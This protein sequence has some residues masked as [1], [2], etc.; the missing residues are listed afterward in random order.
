MTDYDDFV[1]NVATM[2]DGEP[3]TVS[4]AQRATEATLQT[5]A[6]RL[7]KDEA[8]NLVPQ[9][10]PELGGL[11]Y[12]ADPPQ[13]IPV[14]EFLTRV[15]E[16]EGVDVDTARRHTVAV[17]VPLARALGDRE[18]NHVRSRLPTDFRPLLPT[19]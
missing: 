14:R 10:G 2:L 12:T 6:E 11:M 7:G 16:R 18:Y 9:L 15:A 19:G 5:L 4:T 1:L 3:D 13:A 8:A 17:F